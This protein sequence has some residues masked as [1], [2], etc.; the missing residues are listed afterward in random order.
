MNAHLGQTLNVG[1]SPQIFRVH[2][3]GAVLIFE[4]GHVLART[5][6]FLDHKDFI[7][8]RANAEGWLHGLHRNRL[9]FVNDIAD[10]VLFT[11]RHVVFPAAGVGAGS[12]IRVALVDIPGEQA[13]A[14]VGH[15]QRAVDE[16][17]NFHLRHLAA[18]LFDF[19]Q[20]QF[21]RQDHASEAH[22]LPE[23]DRRPVDGVGL[24]R[25]MDR[26]IRKVFPHQHD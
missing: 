14:G 15:A 9:I 2:D 17:L 13:A 3:V 25:K 4:G 18:D 22:L 7:G 23:F 6:G 26:H 5:F 21:T 11:F 12:L 10:V 20:R 16:N 19:I 24:H 8:R 1:D